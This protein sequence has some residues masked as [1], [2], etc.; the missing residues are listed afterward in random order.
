MSKTTS[1]EMSYP[2]CWY[3]GNYHNYSPEMCRDMMRQSLNEDRQLANE[4]LKSYSDGLV[5]EDGL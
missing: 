4:G 3:C 5:K 2:K 1:G